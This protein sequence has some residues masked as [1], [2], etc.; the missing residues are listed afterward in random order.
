MYSVLNTRINIR[1]NDHS[2]FESAISI[3]LLK[4]SLIFAYFFAIENRQLINNVLTL[5]G[6]VQR[7]Y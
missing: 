7:K 5:N 2:T 3:N 1:I 4:I 6:F